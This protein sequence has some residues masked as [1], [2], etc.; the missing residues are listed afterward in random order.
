MNAVPYIDPSRL[1]AIRLPDGFARDERAKSLVFRH[2]DMDGAVTVSCMRHRLGG[3][4]P[5]LFASLPGREKMRGV[6]TERAGDVSLSYGEYEGELQQATEYWRWWVLQRGP[7]G[8]VV[9]FNGAPEDA[10]TW[11]EEVDAL[12][13]G[14]EISANPPLSVEDFTRAAARVYARSLGKPEPAIV[15]P[16][17][18]KTGDNSVLRLENA[19]V[20]Y[21]RAHDRDPGTGPETLLAQWLEQLW[22]SDA[23]PLGAFDDV[24]NLI[25]PVVKPWGFARETQIPLLRRPLVEHELELMIAV[26]TGRTLRFIS[27][28]DVA[29]WEGVSEEDVFFYARENLLAQAGEIQVQALQ[30]PDGQPK[31]VIIATHDS[32][33]AARLTLPNFYERIAAVLGHDLLVGVPN[34]DFL[35]VLSADDPELVANVGAQVA[36]DA[37]TQPYA[38]SGKLFRLT[39]DGLAPYEG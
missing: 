5:D 36:K 3:P 39:K 32:H 8:I 2:P 17:E 22:G 14:I 6:R 19:Y 30:G 27:S 11:R 26:D 25:C 15:K 34:R 24:R 37:Q 35:I 18:L 1:F 23:R 4:G 7:I 29:R 33:D 9:S 16:L 21:L 13:A 10:E 12:V 20:S 38:I 28:E 31:A